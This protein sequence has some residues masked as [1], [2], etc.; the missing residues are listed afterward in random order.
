MESTH[1]PRIVGGIYCKHDRDDRHKSLI[2]VETIV[3]PE[4]PRL[5]FESLGIKSH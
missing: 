2:T 5:E 4:A 1:C 3:K